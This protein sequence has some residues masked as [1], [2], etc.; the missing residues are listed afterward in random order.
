MPIAS[1]KDIDKV[2]IIKGRIKAITTGTFGIFIIFINKYTREIESSNIIASHYSSMFEYDNSMPWD[3]FE[4]TIKMLRFKGEIAS[5]ISSDL[6]LLFANTLQGEAVEEIVE[7]II[8]KRESKIEHTF[9]GMLS[10]ALADKNCI[11]EL[12]W[13]EVSQEDIRLVNDKRQRREREERQRVQKEEVHEAESVTFNVEEGGVIL[14]CSLQISPVS[15]VPITEVRT[16]DAIMVKITDPTERGRYFLNLLK[17]VND[18]GQIIPIPAV[19]KEHNTN[20][21]NE[22]ELLVEIGPGIYGH[23]IEE[24]KVKVKRYI[25]TETDVALAGHG[26]PSGAVQSI[27]MKSGKSKKGDGVLGSMPAWMWVVGGAIVVLIIVLV[28]LL[29]N[30]Q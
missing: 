11:C 13:Q 16:S 20:S 7:A 6:Q 5:N 25:P 27:R 4:D 3:E 26:V 12:A 17:G 18:V 21:L 9:V 10:K 22:H 15:G 23:I 24:E 30:T 19:I 28:V 14:N 8:A 29:G 2:I 1:K